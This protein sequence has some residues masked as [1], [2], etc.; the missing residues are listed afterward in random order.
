L[1][2]IEST[3]AR[4]LKD[5]VAECKSDYA[6]LEVVAAEAEQLHAETHSAM[7][8]KYVSWVS[9]LE[10]ELQSVVVAGCV[11][12]QVAYAQLGGPASSLKVAS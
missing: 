8:V 11:A 6:N 3:K 1:F 12:Y 10:G 4:H 9:S 5:E 7:E 2:V